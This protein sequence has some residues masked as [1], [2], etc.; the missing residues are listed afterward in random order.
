[1]EDRVRRKKIVYIATSRLEQ[2]QPQA[3]REDS[4]PAFIRTEVHR[5]PLIAG[6]GRH[7]SQPSGCSSGSG[8][9]FS[10]RGAEFPRCRPS[11]SSRNTFRAP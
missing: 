9:F 7:S 3:A 5:C 6:R 1:M 2:V 10:P 4:G 8:A 11:R